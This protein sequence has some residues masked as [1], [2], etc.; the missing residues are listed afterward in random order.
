MHLFILFTMFHGECV[1]TLASQ[2]KTELGIP[3]CTE[4]QLTIMWKQ[5]RNKRLSL[6][7]SKLEIKDK[8]IHKFNLFLYL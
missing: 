5:K 1:K 3:L 4:K 8:M 7:S 6:F 2:L